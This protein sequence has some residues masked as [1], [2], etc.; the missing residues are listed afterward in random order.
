MGLGSLMVSQW[1]KLGMYSG[2]DFDTNVIA[3]E[4]IAPALAWTP[5]TPLRL[6][7]DGF[8]YFLSTEDCLS[9]VTVPSIEV[10]ISLAKPV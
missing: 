3:G 9:N 2:V 10:H 6:M 5:L 4:P 7:V 8:A 1:N